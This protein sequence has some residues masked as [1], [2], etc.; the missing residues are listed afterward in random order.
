MQERIYRVPIR[1]TDE[2]RKRLVATWADFQ[3]SIADD[4]VD[5][6]RKRLEACV[7]VQKVVTLNTCCDVVCL[8]FQ[9]PHITTSSFDS[10]QCLD[11]RVLH[12]TR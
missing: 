4:A 10:H 1:I 3:Q 2:L 7:S 9:L 12:F 8:T 11:E 5:Q 6:W